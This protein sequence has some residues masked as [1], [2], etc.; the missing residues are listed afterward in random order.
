MRLSVASLRRMIK[1]K[2]A[3]ESVGQE[4]TSYSRLELFQRDPR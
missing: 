3:V 2:L 1:G 4:G